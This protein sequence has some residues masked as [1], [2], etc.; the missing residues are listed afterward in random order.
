[1]MEQIHY[2]GANEMLKYVTIPPPKEG[3]FILPR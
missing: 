3:G 2:A 1:M